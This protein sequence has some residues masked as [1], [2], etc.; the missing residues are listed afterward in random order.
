MCFPT[1]KM[2]DTV[3]QAVASNKEMLEDVLNEKKF[4]EAMAATKVCPAGTQPCITTV[5]TCTTL[6]SGF[7]APCELTDR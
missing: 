2:M 1:Q 6:M 4:V 3:Q 7:L 5:R